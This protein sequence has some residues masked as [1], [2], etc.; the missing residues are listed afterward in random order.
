MKSFT[1]N[2]IGLLKMLMNPPKEIVNAGHRIINSFDNH[3]YE[4]VKDVWVKRQ[5]ACMEDY[6]NIP[7]IV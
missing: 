7:Q 6:L 4:F 3:I 1:N 2:D 5:E